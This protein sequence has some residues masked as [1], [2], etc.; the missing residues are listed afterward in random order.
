MNEDKS[1]SDGPDVF[2]DEPAPSGM[3]LD[4]VKRMNAIDGKVHIAFD[5]DGTKPVT[6]LIRRLDGIYRQFFKNVKIPPEK[7]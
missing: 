1:E 2:V 3:A 7:K 4:A 5:H 6:I